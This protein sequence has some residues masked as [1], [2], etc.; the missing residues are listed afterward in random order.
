MPK[1]ERPANRIKINIDLKKYM[2]TIFWNPNGFLLV[3]ALD[4][5][6]VFNEDYYIN[7]ILEQINTETSDDQEINKKPFVLHYD[8]AKP[9]T[10]KK[11]KQYLEDN[12]IIRAPQPPYKLL[13]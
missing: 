2:I 11:V 5:N 12:Q 4:D 6:M 13:I 10:S 9:H 1:G 8:N 7:E 3:K